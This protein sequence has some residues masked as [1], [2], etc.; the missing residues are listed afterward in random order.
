[1]SDPQMLEPA[2]ER[3]VRLARLSGKATAAWLIGFLILIALLI[4]AVLRLPLWIDFEIV[5]AGWWLVWLIVLARLLYSG[6][7]ITADHQLSALRNWLG[8]AAKTKEK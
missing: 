3:K 6:Q 2:P 1:M 8:S 4:P 5:L 7:R